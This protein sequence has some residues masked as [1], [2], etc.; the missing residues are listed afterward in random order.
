[1]RPRL[2]APGPCG[3]PLAPTLAKQG[4]FV[5]IAKFA[6]VISSVFAFT[7]AS[8]ASNISPVLLEV[9]L[10]GGLTH[11]EI[12]SSAG[13]RL[14]HDGTITAFRSRNM[15]AIGTIAP[16]KIQAIK[17]ALN[18]LPENAELVDVNP[19]HPFCADAP[20][21]TYEATIPASQKTVALA[22]VENCHTFSSGSPR[23]Y[24]FKEILDGLMALAHF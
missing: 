13:V 7:Y 22:K 9:K 12:P 20:S 24:E 8:L 3:T 1:M 15:R 21:K 10:Q 5:K 4:V 17:A 18:Q 23:E 11:P 14:H 2:M 16:E 19:D 6:V